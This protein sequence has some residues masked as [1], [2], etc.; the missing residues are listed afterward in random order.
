MKT[1]HMRDSVVQD[2]Y[3]P[4]C[5]CVRLQAPGV[6]LKPVPVLDGVGSQIAVQLEQGVLRV[7]WH[8]RLIWYCS[9]D[10]ASSARTPSTGVKQA[11]SIQISLSKEER[12][13]AC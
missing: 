1:V 10:N 4:A 6:D 5:I 9:D 12:G 13:R 2:T 7:L 3:N 8:H 11:C